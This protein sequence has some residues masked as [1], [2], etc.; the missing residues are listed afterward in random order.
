VPGGGV[1][2]PWAEARGILSPVRLPV[3]PPRRQ[4]NERIKWDDTLLPHPRE[5]V[6]RFAHEVDSKVR[7]KDDRISAIFGTISLAT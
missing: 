5:S 1:E 6:E 2:P 7:L 4:A 3:S